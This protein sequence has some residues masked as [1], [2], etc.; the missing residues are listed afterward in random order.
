MMT[1]IRN[2]LG[3]ILSAGIQGSAPGRTVVQGGGG[4][5]Q[6]PVDENAAETNPELRTTRR[7]RQPKRF[8][9]WSQPL[10]SAVIPTVQKESGI[11]L[12]EKVEHEELARQDLEFRRWARVV[13]DNSPAAAKERFRAAVRELGG[14][15]SPTVEAAEAWDLTD[16]VEEARIK[17]RIARQ[18]MQAIALEVAPIIER[19]LGRIE[20]A[21]KDVADELEAAERAQCEALRVGFRPSPKLVAIGH[22][23]WRVRSLF[24]V[25]GST[26]FSPGDVLRL[27]KG[28]SI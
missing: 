6:K 28:L 25:P 15:D 14:K 13:S 3:G 26:S 7:K 18:R 11:S 2:A 1:Q 10:T 4:R 17:V 5:G 19:V 9:G 16:Y 21:A 24:P 23:E 12:A 20:R 22:L 8:E 27:L